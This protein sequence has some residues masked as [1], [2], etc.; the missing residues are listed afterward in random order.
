[1]QITR[2]DAGDARGVKPPRHALFAQPAKLTPSAAP[3]ASQARDHTRRQ[4]PGRHLGIPVGHDQPQRRGPQR[5][6]QVGQQP[7]RSLIGTVQVINHH[8]L[9]GGRGRIP[10]RLPDPLE[11]LKPGSRPAT[12]PSGDRLP[13]EPAQHLHPRP[14]RRRPF[15]LPARPPRHHR[16][17]CPPSRSPGPAGSCRYPAPRTAA[18]TPP[19]PAAACAASESRT[20]S[21]ASLPTSTLAAGNPPTATLYRRNRGMTGAARRATAAREGMWC[22]G[23]PCHPGLVS[24]ASTTSSSRSPDQARWLVGGVVVKGMAVGWRGPDGWGS[25]ADRS[26]RPG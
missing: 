23:R 12:R 16:T 14:Q 3:R 10:Q 13:A 21:S 25:R 2:V 6:A 11:Q 24:L 5:L 20:A 1:M 9:R 19:V 15:T 26:G 8:D 18:P 17:A 4:R 7:Q 22:R